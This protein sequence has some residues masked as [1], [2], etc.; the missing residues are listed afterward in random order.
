MSVNSIIEQLRQERARIETAINA[1][2]G[3]AGKVSSDGSTRKRAPSA[4]WTCPD[5]GRVM[6]G[7]GKGRH[8]IA[9]E[10]ASFPKTEKCSY[11]AKGFPDARALEIHKANEHSLTC[12]FCRKDFADAHALSIHKREDHTE[13]R[14]GQATRKAGS[15]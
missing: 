6:A 1:L 3:S 2:E 8:R 15:A 5:C 11:C 13:R 10:G 12:N 4:P 7:S 9:C 14:G